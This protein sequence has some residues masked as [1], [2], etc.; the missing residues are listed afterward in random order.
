MSDF[1]DL[2]LSSIRALAS[3]DVFKRGMQYHRQGAVSNL[4][5]RGNRLHAEVEGSEDEPYQISIDLTDLSEASCT[6][7][8]DWGDVCKHVVATLLAYSARSDEIEERAP[9]ETTLAGLDRHQLAALVVELAN[10]DPGL[11][12]LI[13]ARSLALQAPAP[14]P[15]APLTPPPDLDVARAQARAVLRSL[16]SSRSRDLWSVGQITYAF[17]E[18]MRL[19]QPYLEADQG[20][21]ALAVLETVTDTFIDRYM[22]LDDSDGES[23]VFFEELGKLWTESLLSAELTLEERREWVKR[24]KA[25]EREVEDYGLEESFSAPILAAEQGW[26]YPPLQRVLEGEITEKGAW[27][28]EAPYCADELAEARLNVLERRGQFQEYLYLAEAEGQTE[29]YVTMLVK[30]DRVPE[31]VEYGL[32]YLGTPDEALVLARVLHERGHVED[33]FRIAENFLAKTPEGEDPARASYAHGRRGILA[34]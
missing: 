28:G 6:C 1:V 7:P 5:K 4:V 3:E 30:L 2:P 18:A 13:E 26:N 11:I 8:Y 34:A 10:V 12:D 27:E 29:R 22:G 9:L 20:N 33:A 24:L 14:S 31:A 25:W 32:R 23:S 16:G 17:D 19:A 21:A 15:D